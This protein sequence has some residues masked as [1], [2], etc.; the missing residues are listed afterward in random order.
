MRRLYFLVPDIET[1]RNIT[2]EVL[3]ARIE[4]RRMHVIA[5]RHTVLEGIPEAT[6]V[7]MSDLVPALEWGLMCGGAV[8][9]LSGLTAATFFDM[10]IFQTGG[11]MVLFFV[12]GGAIFGAWL[13]GMVGISIP[14]RRIRQ[15]Q[16][17]IETGSLLM[18]VDV[19]AGK[20]NNVKQ[21]ITKNYPGVAFGGMEPAMPAFP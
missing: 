8:G 20:M 9:L 7:Q 13:S 4:E 21:A 11:L 10:N 18:L 15:F 5:K 6:I 1:T 14:N 3:L 16:Q 12:L 17:A 19:P 2:D